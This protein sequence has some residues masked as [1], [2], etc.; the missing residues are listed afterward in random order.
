MEWTECLK[1]VIDYIEENLLNDISIEKVASKVY[2]SEFYLQK[3]FKIITGYSIGEYIR[4]RRLY[5][6]ALDVVA[7][8]EKIID[9]AYKYGYDTPESFTKAFTRF[10]GVAPK[11]L[12]RDTSKIKIFLPIRIIV[13]IKEGNDMDYVVEKMKAI[14]VIGFKKFFNFDTSYEKIPKFWQQ[15][16][17]SYM[18][19]KYSEEEQR[20]IEECCIGEFGICI[21]EDKNKSGFNYMIAGVYNG[22][23]V[24]K[25]MEVYEVPALE[26]AKFKCIGPMPEALQTVNTR[27]FNEWLPGNSKYEIAAEI[28]IE[29]YSKGDGKSKE[30]KSEIWIPI[31]RK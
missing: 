1:T 25:G 29:W 28:N 20:A 26:W 17:K 10:H 12:K 31:K 7:E 27:I 9:L 22:G 24:P 5:M 11:K 13:S 14:K 6:A 4:C 2:M 15:F 3:G 23:G 16:S 18:E 8:E 30:Y 19:G 21:C